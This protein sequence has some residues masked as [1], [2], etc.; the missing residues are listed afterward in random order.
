[1]TDKEIMHNLMND[2]VYRSY[3]KLL[4]YVDETTIQEYR[5][6]NKHYIKYI[7]EKYTGIATYSCIKD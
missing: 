7:G 5:K 1:M 3:N 6:Y 4:D 2:G